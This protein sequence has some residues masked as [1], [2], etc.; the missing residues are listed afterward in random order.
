MSACLSG[1]RG[2]KKRTWVPWNWS[3][4]IL[5]DA[6][7]PQALISVFMMGTFI[8]SLW[9]P[10]KQAREG[11][12]PMLALWESEL[13]SGYFNWDYRQTTREEAAFVY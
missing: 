2:G 9:H 7:S 1:A 12:G 13:F 11:Q 4:R 10:N 8:I 3:Y 6:L 5:N